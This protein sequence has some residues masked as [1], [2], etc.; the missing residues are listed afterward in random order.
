[1]L[2]CA[3]KVRIDALVTGL[4]FCVR[5]T[6][7]GDCA[8]V[9]DGSCTLRKHDIVGANRGS[10][11]AGVGEWMLPEYRSAFLL[12]NCVSQNKLRTEA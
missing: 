11:A 8:E 4:P 9:K 12:L 6:G 7:R 1:V 10:V 5:G 2:S 3:P